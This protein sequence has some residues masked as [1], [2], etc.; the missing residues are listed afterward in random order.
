MSHY[1]LL[2]GK[3]SDF[4]GSSAKDLPKI[5][6]PGDIVE[7]DVD[8]VERFGS[9]KFRKLSRK[10]VRAMQADD[11]DRADDEQPRRKRTKKRKE[12]VEV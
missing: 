11:E 10:E 4:R 2:A 5:Y 1:Q 8:L 3:H 7:S 6:T 12:V 9:G